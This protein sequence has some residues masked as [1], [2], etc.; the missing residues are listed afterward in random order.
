ME[1]PTEII[2]KEI[3]DNI[4]A[5]KTKGE[6]TEKEL[7]TLKTTLDAIPETQEKAVLKVK[8]E[9]QKQFD[10]LAMQLAKSPLIKLGGAGRISLKSVLSENRAALGALKRKMASPVDLSI[11]ASDFFPS[12]WRKKT[13]GNITEGGNLLGTDPI[14]PLFLDGVFYDPVR[15]RHIR[16]IINSIKV[17][18]PVIHYNQETGSNQNAA[19]TS[20][21]SAAPQSDFT[22]TG[23]EITV[24]KINQYLTISKEMME[25]ADFVDNYI[26]TRVVSW[27]LMEEDSEL[28]AGNNTSPNLYGLSTNAQAYVNTIMNLGASCNYFDIL[29]QATTQLIDGTNGYYKP[30]WIV[31]H[32]DDYRAMVLSRD[33][34]GRYQFPE[35]LMGENLKIN[36]AIIFKNTVCPKGYF[37]AGDFE[38]GAVLC[39]RDEINITFSN[40]NVDNFIK[41]FITVLIEERLALVIHNTNAFVYGN[42]AAAVASGSL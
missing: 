28:F 40:Q 25:D 5:I 35:A 19:A 10:E 1:N 18:S 12:E 14:K 4:L 31:M 39:F 24:H 30:N 27:L 2:V 23:Q 7:H 21:G 16:E 11:K 3:K 13:A 36:D 34:Y 29:M 33:V 41:G 9:L 8:E 32:P 42:F 22:L 26:R 37:L 20:E 17:D 38:M 6:A 15:P